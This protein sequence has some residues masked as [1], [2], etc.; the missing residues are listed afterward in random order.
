MKVAITMIPVIIVL[1]ILILVLVLIYR[2]FYKRRINRILNG[3]IRDV[4]TSLP[5]LSGVLMVILIIVQFALLINANN[6]ISELQDMVLSMDDDVTRDLNSIYYKI[7]NIKELIESE[8]DI[9]ES[10]NYEF[11]EINTETNTIMVDFFCVLKEYSEDTI[12]TIH[13]MGKDVQFENQGAGFVAETEIPLFEFIS[14]ENCYISAST[15]GIIT[16]QEITDVP[17]GYDIIENILLMIKMWDEQYYMEYNNDRLEVKGKFFVN[18]TSD[19]SDIYLVTY[20]NGEEIER[21]EMTSTEAGVSINKSYDI[22]ETDE[23]IYCV[24]AVY[25]DTYVVRIP[26]RSWSDGNE[27]YYSGPFGSI[28]DMDG[29]VLY[30]N[31]W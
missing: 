5:S 22:D 25:S 3:E 12:L 7:N 23:L 15:N 16:T 31:V 4:H 28:C 30:A 21:M 8:D 9:V 20:I 6:R 26:Y 11:G 13:F 19:Y 29:N 14:D 24:E 18:G 10:F 27:G 2:H 17:Y 1:I